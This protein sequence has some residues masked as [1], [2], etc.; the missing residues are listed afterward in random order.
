M[1]SILVALQQ[2]QEEPRKYGFTIFDTVPQS[3][4]TDIEQ[5]LGRKLPTEIRAF[6]SQWGGFWDDEDLEAV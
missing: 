3:A 1:K 6:Y 4:L 2:I 5:E